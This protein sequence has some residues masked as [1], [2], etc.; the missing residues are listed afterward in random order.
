[1]R[2]SL[3][4]QLRKITSTEALVHVLRRHRLTVL[5]VADLLVVLGVCLAETPC[6]RKAL[7]HLAQH[8]CRVDDLPNL[9]EEAH[10]LLD[11]ELDIGAAV[12][13][14][15]LAAGDHRHSLQDRA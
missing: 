10:A 2:I 8:G 1:A 7:R 5:A 3:C 15:S 6:L 13:L 12:R 11:R 4:R 9:A 14:W